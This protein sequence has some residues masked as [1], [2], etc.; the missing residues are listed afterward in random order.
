MIYYATQINIEVTDEMLPDVQD[1]VI[2]NM[3]SAVPEIFN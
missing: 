3:I 2:S 1:R